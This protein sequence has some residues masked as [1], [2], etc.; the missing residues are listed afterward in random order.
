[1]DEFRD[2]HPGALGIAV[3]VVSVFGSGSEGF[4]LVFYAGLL[5][6]LVGAY[7]YGHREQP[8]GE[9][10]RTLPYGRLV[11]ADS[12]LTLATY[13]GVAL[14]VV[15]G[16]LVFTLFCLIGPIVN[17]ERQSVREAFG[18]SYRLVRPRFWLA[19]LAVTL[20][21]TLEVSLYHGLGGV[22]WERGLWSGFAVNAAL[23]MLV[24]ATVGLLEVV[25]AH[26]LIARDRASAGQ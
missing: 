14:F 20:P 24:G 17:I 1:V 9:V 8:V 25:L 26:E 21:V 2:D 6:G 16:I 19:F 3:F 7:R 5:D 4:A 23:A 13:V 15:P 12:I 22:A 11:A 10:L 18:R